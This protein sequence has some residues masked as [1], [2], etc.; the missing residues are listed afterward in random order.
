MGILEEAIREHLDL[1]RN[2]GADPHEVAQQEREALS[3]A[4]REPETPAPAAA[5]AADG[6]P[7]EAGSP[8]PAPAAEVPPPTPPAEMDDATRVLPPSEPTTPRR[9][10]YGQPTQAID[11]EKLFERESR[12]GGE[13]P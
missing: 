3:P 6:A 8:E 12:S 1:K 5:E 7:P 10:D 13:P 4:V 9:D 2:R 11:T